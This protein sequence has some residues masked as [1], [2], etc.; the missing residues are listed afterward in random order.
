MDC[1]PS[2]KENDRP[3]VFRENADVDLGTAG[4]GIS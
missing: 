3:A 4:I 1:L 2:P